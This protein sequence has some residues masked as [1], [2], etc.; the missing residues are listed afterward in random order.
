MTVSRDSQIAVYAVMA[1]RRREICPARELDAS[2]DACAARD[3]SHPT[4]PERPL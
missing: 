2:R 3:A 1:E 4:C